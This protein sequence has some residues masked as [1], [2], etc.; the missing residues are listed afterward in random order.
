MNRRSVFP[1]TYQSQPILQRKLR[2]QVTTTAANGD[3][4]TVG[5]V[6]AVQIA[7]SASASTTEAVQ[8]FQSVRIRKVEIWGVVS[9]SPNSLTN[10]GLLWTGLNSPS[11]ELTA[12][13][14]NV[15]PAHI[16]AVP[17]KNSQSSWWQDRSATQ[18]QILFEITAPIGA[19]VEI[20][21]DFIMFDGSDLANVTLQSASN[22][23]GVFYP[24]LDSL[25]T[26][27]TAGNGVLVPINLSSLPLASM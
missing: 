8:L 7:R 13:G 20:T 22:S 25:S 4:I 21:L 15:R 27:N 17:P 24:P 1:A 16:S 3:P 19:I 23:V 5:C 14:D 12:S 9:S 6:R 26:G 11:Q 18:T 2:Y 10:V